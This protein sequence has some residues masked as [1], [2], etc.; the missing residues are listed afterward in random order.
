MSPSLGCTVLLFVTMFVT[1][2]GG[3]GT[4][5]GPTHLKNAV[6][7]GLRRPVCTYS[8]VARDPATGEMGVAV[9]S[10]WFSVGPIVPWAEAG[11][12]AV[13]TQSLADPAYGPLG[14]ELMRVGRTGPEAL[15]SVLAGDGGREVRQVAMIDATGRVAAHTGAKCIQPAGHIV[16]TE[17]QFSV[18]A[19]LMSND[20]IW[21]EMA[22]A[23]RS[24]KGDLADRMLAALDAAEAAG[25]DIRGRQSAALL[26]VVGTSTGKPWV[27]RRFDLRVEDHA[28]PLVE[29]RRLV[30]LQRA[31]LHMNAG[32]VAIEKEDF[33][34]AVREYK[35]A[36]ACAP[37]IVEIPFWHAV[38]LVNAGKADEAMPLFE[39]VFKKEPVWAELV[40]RLV[41]CEL[42]K[43]DEALVARIRGLVPGR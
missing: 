21:G 5:P 20:R 3:Q 24:A 39:E 8:I 17:G 37:Q 18:Q 33:D 23:Y 40:P 38:S 1:M 12:G 31:Y 14:L 6:S 13:A 42:L 30:K 35:A 11:V 7:S 41:D 15:G 32:D 9:Q 10:H 36:Q 29:L 22:R 19:N 25:G 16:D 26:V 43:V 2:F 27:D 28:Q 4:E 34:A